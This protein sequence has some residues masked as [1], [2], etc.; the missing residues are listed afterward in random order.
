MERFTKNLL[1]MLAV[2]S[3]ST[4]NAMN[5]FIPLLSQKRLGYKR[6]NKKGFHRQKNTFH[7]FRQKRENINW[8]KIGIGLG[9]FL[10]GSSIYNHWNNYNK[11]KDLESKINRLEDI[12]SRRGDS[13]RGLRRDLRALKGD[14]EKAKHHAVMQD[15]ASCDING[16]VNLLESLGDFD[17]SNL[18]QLYE[19]QHG[20]YVTR[21]LVRALASH[22]VTSCYRRMFDSL[23]DGVFQKDLGDELLNFITSTP[24]SLEYYYF[25]CVLD[26][27]GARTDWSSKE[28]GLLERCH[29]KRHHV[30]GG[31]GF[32]CYN[33]E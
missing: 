21:E 11:I 2:V 12:Q 31:R 5:R 22:A 8:G 10:T 7:G 20:F 13:L 1:L 23:I 33:E 16:I 15:L 17:C 24:N 9:L 14:L 30:E 6:T 4:S 18:L 28:E 19:N 3:V 25:I 32:Y 26:E 27:Y 29:A